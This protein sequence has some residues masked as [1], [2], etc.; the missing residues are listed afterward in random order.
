[1]QLDSVF[2]L[3]RTAGPSGAL[4][5]TKGRAALTLAAVIR[6]GGGCTQ[7]AK[8]GILPSTAKTVE[9]GTNLPFVIPSAA[10]GSAVLLNGKTLSNCKQNCHPDR[11]EA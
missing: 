11:S 5:M 4:G 6:D 9:E 1:L 3:R 10:E 7:S 8:R 2:P